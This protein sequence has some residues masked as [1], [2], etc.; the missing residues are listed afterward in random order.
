ML[1]TAALKIYH[2]YVYSVLPMCV[3]ALQKRA[4]DRSIDACEPP[5]SYREFNSGPLENQSV[6]LT[7][8]PFLQL[9]L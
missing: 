2:V 9:L 3:P 1:R 5:C 6:P 7:S 4:P 8:E